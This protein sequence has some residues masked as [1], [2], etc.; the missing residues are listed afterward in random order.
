MDGPL[1]SKNFLSCEIATVSILLTDAG[2]FCL[3][4]SFVCVC[5]A[6][7][8]GVGLRGLARERVVNVIIMSC[9][10]AT[11]LTVLGLNEP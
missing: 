4:K 8:P 10:L 5:V 11:T 3:W 6:P 1:T 2:C 9:I 7:E